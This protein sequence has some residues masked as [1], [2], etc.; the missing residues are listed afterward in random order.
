MKDKKN[1]L[2]NGIIIFTIC[3]IIRTIE[4]IFI[5]TDETIFAE[6][7]INKVFGIIL[8]F[9]ILHSL[10]WKW[11]DMFKKEGMLKNILKD[12]FYVQHFML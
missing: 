5:R 2:R 10:N 8:L 9:I 4:V 7:F 3:L 11:K 12:F 6:C 1:V